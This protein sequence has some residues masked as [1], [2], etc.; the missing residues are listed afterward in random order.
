MP[1]NIPTVFELKK[2]VTQLSFYPVHALQDGDQ[3]RNREQP[4]A[5]Y[6]SLAFFLSAQAPRQTRDFTPSYFTEYNT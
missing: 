4:G 6:D 1:A 2:L 5:A 3:P